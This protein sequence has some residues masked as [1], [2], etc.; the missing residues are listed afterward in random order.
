MKKLKVYKL[1]GI[2]LALTL[3]LN[4]LCQT[5]FA[6]PKNQLFVKINVGEESYYF[7]SSEIEFSPDFT[8]QLSK[9]S[10][11]DERGRIRSFY[12]GAKITY[13]L[14]DIDLKL[15]QIY[16]KYYVPP[17][18]SV[19]TFSPDKK[20]MFSC[21]E[22]VKGYKID[23]LKLK[24][25]IETALKEGRSVEISTNPFLFEG[26]LCKSK[27]SKSFH[28][29]S[30]FSTGMENS[31]PERKHNIALSISKFNGLMLY[32]GEGVSFNATTGKRTAENGYKEAKIISNGQ[33][34]EGFG[35]GVCQSSTT[36]Y[37]AVLK[38]DL[39]V[40]EH[41]HHSLAV[42][43]VPP[44]FDAMVNSGTAD[45]KFVNS[46]DNMIY[47][48]T[49]TDGKRVTVQIYGEVLPYTV[50]RRS[51]VIERTPAPKEK[52]VEN[53]K[54]MDKVIFTDDIYIISPSK[55]GLKSEG[56]LDY[57][58]EGVIFKSVRLRKDSYAPMVGTAVKG[59]NIRPVEKA[60]SGEKTADKGE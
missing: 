35:G 39:K 30:Q 57:V 5:A 55:G 46:S 42:S 24:T 51:E 6:L 33:M 54:Y 7:D 17:V 28:L 37:N 19:V 2:F 27:V 14:K 11:T 47:I 31:I 60:E 32:P 58:K 10:A 12:K 53:D 8:A 48:K 23:L 49:F 56:Y 50:Q 1:I 36:L 45:L 13:A 59:K 15:Q 18:N 38:A 16:D 4:F 25:E 44:S 43:Y 26:E 22:S 34:V 29:R 40:T 41:H 3:S 9:S 21:T 20:P 52:F